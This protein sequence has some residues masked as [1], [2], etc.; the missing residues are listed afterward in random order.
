VPRLRPRHGVSRFLLPA[1]LGAI[2][3]TTLGSVVTGTLF[4]PASAGE[5][6]AVQGIVSGPGTGASGTGSAFAM[7]GPLAPRPAHPVQLEAGI[8]GARRRVVVEPRLIPASALTAYEWPLPHGRITLPFGPSKLGSRIVDGEAFHDGLDLAT[9]CGDRI[10]AAHAG[11]VLAAGRHYD[12]QMGWIGDLTSYLDRLDAN[13]LWSTLPIVVVIDDGN[14]YRSIY[15][16]LSKTV[17]RK[18]DAVDAGALIGYEGKTGRASGCHLHYGLFSPQSR[19]RFGIDPGVVERM[20]LPPWQI[21][22][23]D[24]LLVLPE[25]H[26]ATPPAD[27]RAAP[28]V[29]TAKPPLESGFAGRS[30]HAHATRRYRRPMSA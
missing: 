17:V 12:A 7:I 25:R 1:A 10:V 6:G 30:L 2:V 5:V 16:H 20:K 26:G 14:G 8:A 24:P 18:G 27:E 21:A 15:A 28:T 22:R 9:F 4:P 23:V 29:G 11:V 19:A 3:L 13:G